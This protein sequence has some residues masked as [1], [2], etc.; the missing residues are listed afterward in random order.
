MAAHTH[1]WRHSSAHAL[2]RVITGLMLSLAITLVAFEWSFADPIDRSLAGVPLPPEDSME[3]PMAHR[4]E[5]KAAAATEKKPK[6]NNDLVLPLPD[7][8]EKGDE[9]DTADGNG[10]DAPG[11]DVTDFSG[12]LAP[13]TSTGPEPSA[14]LMRPEVMPWFRDCLREPVGRRDKCTQERMQ[15]TLARHF[16]VP[17]SVRKDIRT[18]VTFEVDDKGRIGRVV[19]A[20]KVQP[21]VEAEV[22]RVF[23]L[24]P[25]LIPGSQGGHPVG[26]MYQ[27]PLNIRVV[28]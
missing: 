25:E 16:K 5:R 3:L 6:K 12:L 21:D 2:P 27:I 11:P 20:P 13:D 24:M 14:F 26:V 1:S 8:P 28:P 23:G 15:S 4:A 22:L 9:S 10:S 19:C 18:V 7:L 17:S